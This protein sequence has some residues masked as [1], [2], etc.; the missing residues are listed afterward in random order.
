MKFKPGQEVTPNKKAEEWAIIMGLIMPIPEFGKVYTIHGYPLE[1]FPE[2][3]ELEEFAGLGRFVYHE[4]NFEPLV[5]MEKIE[6]DLKEVV[7]LEDEALIKRIEEVL[8]S[9]NYE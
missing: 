9:Y 7:D 3:V 8:K 6:L 2:M 1:A 4:N 5:P